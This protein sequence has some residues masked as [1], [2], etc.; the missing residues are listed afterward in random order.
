M[1][2]F[3]RCYIAATIR[4]AFFFFFFFWQRRIDHTFGTQAAI[5]AAETMCNST[6]PQKDNGSLFTHVTVDSD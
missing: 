6:I 3:I 1:I 5:I 4:A 2:A